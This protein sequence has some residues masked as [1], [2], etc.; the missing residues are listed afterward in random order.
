MGGREETYRRREDQRQRMRP[1]ASHRISIAKPPVGRW[2]GGWVGGW[3][4]RWVGG[5]VDGWMDWWVG[6]WEESFTYL[7]SI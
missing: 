5:W 2:V 6:G 3:V 1:R 7:G 4:D